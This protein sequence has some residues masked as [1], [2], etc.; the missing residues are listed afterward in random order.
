MQQETAEAAKQDRAFMEYAFFQLLPRVTDARKRV[1]YLDSFVK[2]Y[3]DSPNVAQLNFQYFMA[4]EM[5]GDAVKADDYGEKAIAADPNNIEVLNLVAYD[6]ALARRINTDKAATYA[7][8]VLTLVPAAKKP[9]GMTDEQFKAQQNSQL[10]MAHLVLGYTNLLKAGKSH[11]AGPAIQEFK[12]ASD[13]LASNPQLQGQALYFLG[14][15]YEDIYP[16]NHHAATEALT[17][18]ASLNS[19]MQ[20]QARDLLAKVR[21]AK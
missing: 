14:Y 2:S 10:G 16:A 21:A 8:R 7:K 20:A 15:S 17:R 4:Y 13:L 11:R 18:A 12:L 6:Y 19:P 9:D 1:Q 5:A 3:P